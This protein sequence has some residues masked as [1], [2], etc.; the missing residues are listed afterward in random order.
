MKEYRD[1]TI[2]GSREVLVATIAEIER[3][4]SDGW[5]RNQQLEE[6]GRARAGLTS[7]QLRFCFTC[8]PTKSRKGAALALTSN[9][10]ENLSL[11]NIVPDELGQLTYDEFND[12]L[13]EFL[14]SFARPAAAKTGATIETSN[15]VVTIEDWFSKE[16]ADKLRRFLDSTHGI[17][18]HPDGHKRWMEFL[19]AAQREGAKAHGDLLRR[20]LVEDAGCLEYRAQELASEYQTIQDY[21]RSK[22]DF[23]GA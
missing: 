15:G 22:A 1:L 11:S 7:N 23:V 4:L 10:E 21:E 8:T 14:Q 16:T 19:V 2:S 6:Q 17:T 18:I 12:I 5:S 20:W 13:E 3:T 9:S